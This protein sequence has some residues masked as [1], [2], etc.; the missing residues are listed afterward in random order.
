MWNL[1]LLTILG[2]VQILVIIPLIIGH[3]F[4]I[5]AYQITDQAD[6]SEL[7][8]KLKIKRATILRDSKPYGFVYGKWYIGYITKSEGEKEHS[9]SMYIS[10]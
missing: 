4:K 7:I 6:I 5:Q 9:Q 8:S 1:V 3:I 10:L 2:S